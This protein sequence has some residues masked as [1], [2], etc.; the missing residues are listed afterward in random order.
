MC[1]NE[2][3]LSRNAEAPPMAVNLTDKTF[4]DFELGDQANAGDFRDREAF[5]G[6]IVATMREGVWFLDADGV[7]TYVNRA[8]ASMLG[9]AEV[10]MLGRSLFEFMDEKAI[11]QAAQYM[12]RRRSGISEIHEF[13]FRHRDGS[14]VW[15]TLSA[16]SLTSSTGRFRGTMA[17]IQ[18][19][20]PQKKVEAELRSRK[21]Q[22]RQMLD[23]LPLM[24]WSVD[25]DL[26]VTSS[27]G[28]ALKR[29]GL[30]NNELVGISLMEYVSSWEPEKAEVML[31]AHQRAVAGET[32]FL[33]MNFLGRINFNI[34]S[35]YYGLD[36][37]K[38][39]GAIGV[40]LDVTDQ[41]QAQQ[42]LEKS[43]NLLRTILKSAPD[44]I[45]TVD[46]EGRIISFN[47]SAMAIF[48]RSSHE[49]P[50]QVIQE[51]LQVGRGGVATFGDLL[52]RIANPGSS[53]QA[54][55]S[56]GRLIPVEVSWGRVGE[57]DLW[58]L[59]VR[60]VSGLR[61]LQ[62]QVVSIAEEQQRKLGREIHDDVGQE[63]TGVNL[64]IDAIQLDLEKISGC[65]E[66]K[67]LALMISQRMRR[68]QSL[69]RN[70][71]HG[72]LVS[73]LD[74]KGLY[75]ALA[76]MAENISVLYGIK[77]KWVCP[78]RPVHLHSAT[79][80]QLFRIAQEATSNALRHARASAIQIELR[81]CETAGEIEL[82]VAD[83]GR[84]M[85]GQQRQG[86]GLRIMEYRAGLIDGR[87]TIEHGKGLT[88]VCRVK[89]H[90]EDA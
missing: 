64:L 69:I 66:P 39:I 23:Q 88:V 52:E 70:I 89:E 10:E 86:M 28:S 3:E 59:V 34:I 63:L 20:S 17:T 72:L 85:V 36:N 79:A 60:D 14:D 29:L 50:R 87:L 22:L 13:R 46:S 78:D 5:L 62:S 76:S 55:S 44:A 53:C 48:G 26:R 15:T 75:E 35:P 43:E 2:P 24:A 6:L 12:D 61:E 45:L 11:E 32:I 19:I 80:T 42:Q 77:C 73:D 31:S 8:M 67:R 82:R 83:N 58:T 47:D 84:G 51:M 37:T 41:V 40:A 71:S 21:Q 54:R 38:I 33:E 1:L 18:D 57:L 4:D 16:I 68:T 74:A 30:E 7:T 25:S 81:V 56:D 49:M 27:Y 9:W 90:N 65:D